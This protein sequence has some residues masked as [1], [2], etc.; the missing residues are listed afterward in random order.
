MESLPNLQCVATATIG[1]L[2]PSCSPE[3]LVARPNIEVLLAPLTATKTVAA[4]VVGN[5][6]GTE[7]DLAQPGPVT[8]SPL[9]TSVVAMATAVLASRTAYLATGVWIITA[10]P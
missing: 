8:P 9:T 1:T 5:A 6:K 7:M 3:G 10:A 2:L 4:A